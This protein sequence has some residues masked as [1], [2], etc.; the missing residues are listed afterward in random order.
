MRRYSFLWATGLVFLVTLVLHWWLGWHAY[1]SEAT[2][3]GES[4]QVR[5]FLVELGRDTFENWQSE[6]LQLCWQ[7]AA[8]A[9]L[10]HAGSPQ[11]R[12]D[13][14]RMEAKLNAL[15]QKLDPDNAEALIADLDRRWPG[16]QE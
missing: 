9:F 16:R 8:L 4:P 7:V 6:F 1:V 14:E 2:Q 3:H 15:L 5:D 11:S 12:G 13:D 10:Y